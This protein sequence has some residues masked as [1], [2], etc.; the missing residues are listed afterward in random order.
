MIIIKEEKIPIKMWLDEIEPEAE[1]QARNLANLPYAFH[2]IA[3]M[4]DAHVGYG[5]PIGG[6]LAT[7]K[8]IV[9]NA[10]GVDI[11]CGVAA[12]KTTARQANKKALANIL[13]KL[14]KAIPTGFAHHKKPQNWAGFDRAPAV[15]VIQ[16][17][18][19]SARRQIG[20]L[21]GGNHFL[22]ILQEIDDDYWPVKGQGY[23]WLMLHSGSRNFGLKVARAY[24]QQAR[25]FCDQ[26][27]IKLPDK[28]LA[29]LFLA[30]RAGQEYWQ[31]MNY[32]Q[33]FAQANRALMMRRLAEIVSD[34]LGCDFIDFKSEFSRNQARSNQYKEEKIVWI[35]HNYAAQEEHFGRPVIVHRKGAVRAAKGQIGLVP[36][37]MGTPT[38]VVEGLGNPE[39]FCS[40]AHGAGRVLGRREA[41]RR[42]NR[43]QV[44]AAIQGIVFSG[45]GGK[46]DEAPQVYKDIEKVMRQQRDLAKPIV[47]LRPLAVMIGN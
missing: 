17:E 36:G 5:M 15:P 47:K 43:A 11:G 14:K 44:E 35:H 40:C 29:F 37:S 25:Q 39:S 1:A 34:E 28:D 10:V 18:L 31:A 24:H 3:I 26:H 27:N 45:W 19:A 12:V 9:P 13:D 23:I 16:K 2:H 4:P 32:C 21:G 7:E 38:Y 20:T 33:E 22:E 8:I 42:L 41:N 46:F 30:S 6:V